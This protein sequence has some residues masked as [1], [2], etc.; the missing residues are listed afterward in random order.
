V[1]QITANEAIQCQGH[2]SI[3]ICVRQYHQPCLAEKHSVIIPRRSTE[4]LAPLGDQRGAVWMPM[5]LYRV[6]YQVRTK[7][8]ELLWQRH[9]SKPEN[10][11]VPTG[12]QPDL[13]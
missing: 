3:S 2:N 12:C 4:K 8:Q 13:A 9:N 7:C 11:S 6:K 10:K 1:L 5:L